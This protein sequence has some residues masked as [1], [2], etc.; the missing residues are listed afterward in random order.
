MVTLGTSYAGEGGRASLT[1]FHD[2]ITNRSSYEFYSDGTAQYVAV[3][4]VTV[5]GAVADLAA[6][7]APWFSARASATLQQAVD[8]STRLEFPYKPRVMLLG[9][10]GVKPVRDLLLSLEQS[11]IGARRYSGTSDLNRGDET[12]RPWYPTALR[13]DLQLARG[14]ILFSRVENVFDRA[15]WDFPGY[16]LPGRQFFL[17]IS[18][19][20]KP[21]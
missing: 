20:E 19:G 11:Y 13:A 6:T 4:S 15:G 14:W 7:P 2:R 8:E 21:L 1:A 5:K 3:P 12:L 17:G 10:V 9:T 16:P 18:A